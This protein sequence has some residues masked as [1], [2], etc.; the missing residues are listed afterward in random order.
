MDTRFL[1]L[2]LE[3]DYDDD[4]ALPAEIVSAKIVHNLRREHKHNK[5]AYQG[6]YARWARHDDED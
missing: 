4:A 2:A 1:A 5:A 6:R 3:D